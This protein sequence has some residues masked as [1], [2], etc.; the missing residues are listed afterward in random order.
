MDQMKKKFSSEEASC[1]SKRTGKPDKNMTCKEYRQAITKNLKHIKTRSELETVFK[2]SEILA[3]WDNANASDIYRSATIFRL[4]GKH[5][6]A[7]HL[8]AIYTFTSVYTK[9]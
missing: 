1:T 4:F 9:C 3:N 7:E 5:V 6:T 2:Y 8:E